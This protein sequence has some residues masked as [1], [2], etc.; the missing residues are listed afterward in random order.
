MDDNSADKNN[1]KYNKEYGEESLKVRIFSLFF[2]ILKKEDLNSI[3][4]VFFLLLEMFQLIS[5]SFSDPVTYS[6][7]TN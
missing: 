5:Y 4:C 7:L 1:N 2:Y 6:K 3:I